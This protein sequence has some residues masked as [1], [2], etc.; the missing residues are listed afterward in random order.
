[1]RHGIGGVE[2]QGPDPARRRGRRATPA[3]LQ[4]HRS[5]R[6]H[7]VIAC[8]VSHCPSSRL[9]QTVYLSEKYISQ[10]KTGQKGFTNFKLSTVAYN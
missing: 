2:G 9:Q 6:G 10:D 1:M 3:F 8:L 7:A 5:P 4:G